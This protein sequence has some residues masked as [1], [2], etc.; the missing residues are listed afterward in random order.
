MNL[1]IPALMAALAALLCAPAAARVFA[2]RCGAGHRSRRAAL[3]A[4]L[5]AQLQR[6]AE[7]A[8]VSGTCTAAVLAAQQAER[9]VSGVLAHPLA[10]AAVD[11]QHQLAAA[12]Q[13]VKVCMACSWLRCVPSSVQWYVKVLLSRW[14]VPQIH[15]Y[16]VLEGWERCS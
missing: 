6:L 8:G 4:A 13:L 16:T 12:V 5:A 10:S 11:L 2:E 1:R 3:A 9:L 7:A 14:D 15:A